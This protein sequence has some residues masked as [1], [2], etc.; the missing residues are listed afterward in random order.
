MNTPTMKFRPLLDTAILMAVTLAVGAAA[1]TTQS[2]WMDEGNAIIKALMPSVMEMWVFAK[3]LQGSEIQMPLFMLTLWGWE[4]IVGD[5]EYALRAINL[6]LLVVMVLAFRR[7]RFWPLVCLT[8]PFVLYYVGELR[9]YMFQMAGSAVGFSALCRIL[10][11]DCA[12]E[13]TDGV[14]ALLFSAWFM[15]ATSLTAAVCAVGLLLGMIIARPCWLQSKRFWLKVAGWAPFALL[16]IG[17]Y[18]YTL[19]EG[20]RGT[21]ARGGGL[22]S[23]GFGFYEMIGLLG[24]GPGRDALRGAHILGLFTSH[25]WLPL[26]AMVI[27]AAWYAGLKKFIAPYTLRA[28]IALACTV[29]VPMWVFAGVSMAANFSVLGRHLSPLIP[30]LL[31][32][33]ACA[34]ESAVTR[35]GLRPVVVGAILCAGVSSVML[36]VSNTHA[37]DDYRSAT[38]LA[39]EELRKGRAVL[40]QADMGTPRYYAFREGGMPLVHYIQRLESDPPSGLI[41]TDTIFINRPD[42]R[43]AKLDH[44]TILSKDG[45]KLRSTLAGF[46]IW[47]S[48]GSNT[49]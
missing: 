31:L 25:P 39:L 41:F 40:W 16:L 49:R 38:R 4:K 42:I 15:A 9:P 34:C 36:R 19:M 11:R 43:Y 8:S 24:L 48:Q 30:V 20:F 44:H 5:A 14:H 3:H 21:S 35:P 6:P 27:L 13:N 37:R 12:T 47:E 23:M 26:V 33:L 7:Y 18:G 22:L 1:I 45:F 32:P 46:E 29:L 2:L 28:R 10:Q 17:Y